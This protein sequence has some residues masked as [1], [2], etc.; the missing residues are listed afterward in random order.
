MLKQFTE[1][2]NSFLKQYFQRNQ[3]ENGFSGDKKRTGWKLGQKRY[4]RIDTA[5][6]LTGLWHNMYW[7]AD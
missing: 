6:I 1:D 4:D 7:L 2:T 5:N 3:S